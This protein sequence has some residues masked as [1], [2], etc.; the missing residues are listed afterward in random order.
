MSHSRMSAHVNQ[1]SDRT[2]TRPSNLA[3]TASFPSPTPIRIDV[4]TTQLDRRTAGKHLAASSLQA[5]ALDGHEFPAGGGA[6]RPCTCSADAASQ[7][8]AHA[9]RLGP[10][11]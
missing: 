10:R 1:T 11:A 2:Q 9:R 4:A 5:A 3:P 7:G 8:G 6:G